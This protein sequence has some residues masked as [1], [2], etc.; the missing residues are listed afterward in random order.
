MPSKNK[1]V[2]ENNIYENWIKV[3]EEIA[4]QVPNYSKIT[5][6]TNGSASAMTNSFGNQRASDS[7][8]FETKTGEITETKLYK[9]AKNSSKVRGWVFTLHVGSWGGFF[10]KFITVIA[11]LIGTSLPITGYYFWIKRLRRK[12][13]NKI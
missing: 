8:K 3:H 1:N 2:S 5:I 7:F 11:A 12:R 13:E 6:S 9:D 4:K 10:S